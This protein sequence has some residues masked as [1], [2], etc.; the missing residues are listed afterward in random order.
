M[1]KYETPEGRWYREQVEAADAAEAEGRYEERRLARKFKDG[2]VTFDEVLQ[3][4]L[5]GKVFRPPERFAGS[6]NFSDIDADTYGDP[7][8]VLKLGKDPVLSV[9]QFQRIKYARSGYVDDN[10]Q[11]NTPR[12]VEVDGPPPG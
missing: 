9:E 3:L 5:D 6:D 4:F 8:A 1:S 7:F 12:I 2:E 11:R 10:D